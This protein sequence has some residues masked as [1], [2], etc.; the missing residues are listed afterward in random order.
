M[1][2]RPTGVRR[3][4][5]GLLLVLAAGCSG[6]LSAGGEI[7]DCV[8]PSTLVDPLR[9][10]PGQA[11]TVTG[12]GL[13]TCGSDDPLPSADV[14]FRQ[15]ART[16]PLGQAQ[17]REGVLVLATVVPRWAA[18]GQAEVQVEGTA[19]LVLV[20]GDGRGG[21]PPPPPPPGPQPLVVE[22]ADVPRPA[23][24]G[25]VV[26]HA[27]VSDFEVPYDQRQLVQ[28]VPVGT[29]R[30]DFGPLKASYWTVT[31]YVVPCAQAGCP[32]PSV[33]RMLLADAGM[34]ATGAPPDAC[35]RELRLLD[36]PVR[37]R[38]VGGAECV[39]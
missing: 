8:A 34:P 38:W 2:A 12:E 22:V 5:A 19:P 18:P 25:H 36:A 33:Q 20:V 3:V 14:V 13:G 15:G 29:A 35:A 27:E 21:F 4:A 37:V 30:V 39:S 17:D 10:Q 7:V 26:V 32:P 31:V 1:P 23:A 24:G 16:E 6:P 28:V 9:A 11:I